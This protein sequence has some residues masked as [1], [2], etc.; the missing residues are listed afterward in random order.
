MKSLKDLNKLARPYGIELV[1]GQGYFYSGKN[2]Y[3]VR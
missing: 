3:I 2:V 1:K